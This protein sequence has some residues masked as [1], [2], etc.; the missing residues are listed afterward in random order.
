MDLSLAWKERTKVQESSTEL[1]VSLPKMTNVASLLI[2]RAKATP[3][4]VLYAIKQTGPDGEPA[5][6]PKTA[7][8]FL[9]D[10]QAIARGLI[11]WGVKP[12]DSVIIFSPTR[13]EWTLLD[14]A[15]SYAGGV[16]VPIYETSSDEQIEWVV[17][18]SR[19]RFGFADD[20]RRRDNL[21]RIARLP[22]VKGRRKTDFQARLLT[23][24][25]D[26]GLDALL[27]RGREVSDAKLEAARSSRTLDDVASIVY[28][29]GTTGRAKGCEITH[30]NF[31]LFAVNIEQ[32][33]PTLLL[34]KNARTLMFLPLAHVLARAVQLACLQAGATLTHTSSAQELLE[35]MAA[36]K[37]TFLLVVPRVF[38][39]V[40]ERAR[41]KAVAD[42][43][44][45][46]FDAA[47]DTA[48]AYSQAQDA[49][50]RRE[51]RGPGALLKVRHAIFDKLVFGKL[52]AAFGG[53]LTNSVSGA[54]PLNPRLAHF[55]R[56]I[57]LRVLEGYG[58]TE[59]TAPATA[60]TPEY[61][62]V[63]TVGIPIPGT[64]VRISP[65]DEVLIKGVGVFKGYHN[66]PEATA[67]AFEDGYFKTGDMG[68][69]DEN[70][71]LTITG[72]LKDIVVTA[73]GK[74][75]APG[76]MEETIR[77]N[78]VVSYAVVVGEGK[79]FISALISLDADGLDAAGLS[80]PADRDQILAS[81]QSSVDKA[82]AS[83]S[84]AEQ[85]RKFEILD[86]DISIESG[87][88]TPSLKLKRGA[89][90]EQYAA[91]VDALYLN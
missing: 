53:E 82:N 2:E 51:G 77:E 88:L 19:A 48:V 76:P 20:A 49:L 37:P 90:V 78:P 1:L 80:W 61:T 70:G 73:G 57:G 16:T 69:L 50:A 47:V 30:G 75:V 58:L 36:F 17:K 52:R 33:L 79:P 71:Y 8:E 32:W 83:V 3:E 54:S 89:V 87:L 60:N 7:A 40:F 5:W 65:D 67:A 31:A 81:V 35:D 38:E 39:K 14:L 55:F 63:G 44:G 29:S 43:K 27:E 46:I 74:N 42:G 22:G 28:T 11:A 26:D 34:G 62:R 13:Y 18:D 15:I 72:R 4:R 24:S 10:V 23:A 21:E 86:A 12:G 85:I 66:N 91:A 45:T 59:T 56:G 84:R 9:A 64:S 68:A 25:G 41:S 6:I